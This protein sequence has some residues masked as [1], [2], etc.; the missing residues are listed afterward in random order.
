MAEAHVGTRAQASGIV[1]DGPESNAP[2]RLWSDDRFLSRR[3]EA[4]SQTATISGQRPVRVIDS[5]AT[6]LVPKIAQ[7]PV[8]VGRNLVEAFIP[9]PAREPDHDLVLRRLWLRGLTFI[10]VFSGI[11]ALW[12]V[13]VTISSAVI[14]SGQFVTDSSIK[15]VQHR[16]GGIVGKLFVREGDQVKE[17]DLLVRLDETVTRSNLQ[18]VV[19]QLDELAARR[20]RLVAERDGSTTMEES[21]DLQER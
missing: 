2:V 7:L 10:G 6:S 4:L 12:S 9:A 20:A 1:I 21:P 16:T 14:A 3:L 13:T 5:V 19:R 17:G 11:V 18:I 8:V 15:K